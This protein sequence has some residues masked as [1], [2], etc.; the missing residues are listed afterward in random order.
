MAL[1]VGTLL[2]QKVFLN[3]GMLVGDSCV[4]PIDVHQCI[5]CNG[6]HLT[7][8]RHGIPFSQVLKLLNFYLSICSLLRRLWGCCLLPATWHGIMPHLSLWIPIKQQSTS[9]TTDQ[10]LCHSAPLSQLT[11]QNG[12]GSGGGNPNLCQWWLPICVGRCGSHSRA[13]A[14]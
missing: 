3:Q 8:Y 4:R 9:L 14:V 11:Q 2:K 7:H 13:L 1:C 6:C 10:E 12:Y 5:N